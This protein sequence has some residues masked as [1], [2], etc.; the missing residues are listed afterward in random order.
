MASLDRPQRPPARHLQLLLKQGK[1][2]DEIADAAEDRR[3]ARVQSRAHEAVAALGPDQ[4]GHRRR[5]PPRGRRL[6]AR[7]ADRLAPRRDARV[8]RGLRRRAAA[9]RAPSP[10]RCARSPATRL[11][12]IPAEPAEVDEAFEAL[13][14][15]TARQEEVQRSSQLGTKILFGALGLSSRSCSSSCSASS[16]ATTTPR[17][18]RRPSP[19]PPGRRRRETPRRR[20]AGRA[21]PA[22]RARTPRPRRETA[23]VNY[24]NANQFKLLHRRQGAAARAGGL[25]VRGVALHLAE[26]AAL[27]RLPEGDGQRR[28][29]ARGRRRPHAADA[30]ATAGPASRASASRSP[31]KPGRSC[32]AARSR[33][34]RRPRRRPRRR[35]RRGQQTQ[36][37]P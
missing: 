10:A 16:T 4:P 1:S 31:T 32:C 36:T 19:A 34:R 21:A 6:P 14:K 27:H 30:D 35:R 18:R 23:I 28:G 17:P 37:T 9:G 13:D 8:P 22:A 11:P 29:H 33:S 5:P 26:R 20:P 3:R 2:Y 7:P 15:R 25:G 12:E 24:Q